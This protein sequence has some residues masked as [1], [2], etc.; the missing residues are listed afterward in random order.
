MDGQM[1]GSFVKN[2]REAVAVQLTTFNGHK[3][4]DVR[5]VIPNPDGDSTPTKKGVT[6]KPAAL[7]DLI[8]LLQEAHAAAMQAGWCQSDGA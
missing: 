2:A 3:L 6:L 7:P 1:I 8:K 5:V 4:R